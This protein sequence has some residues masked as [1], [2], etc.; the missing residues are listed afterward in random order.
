MRD[1]YNNSLTPYIS[2]I[3]VHTAYRKS[4]RQVALTGVKTK[5]EKNYYYSNI[6]NKILV[7]RSAFFF[8]L[9]ESCVE[10]VE[11][12]QERYTQSKPFYTY[13]NSKT[14]IPSEP[15]VSQTRE[16][17]KKFRYKKK[18]WSKIEF[19]SRSLSPA[20]FNVPDSVC[21]NNF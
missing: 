15:I 9:V 5:I 3:T 2:I 16:Q 6:L 17:F 10:Q 1:C 21:F 8:F 4:I 18:K 12:C 14:T 7:G 11:H 20:H 13:Y 19:L